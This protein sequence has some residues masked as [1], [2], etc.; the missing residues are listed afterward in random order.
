[1]TIDRARFRRPVQP[2]VTLRIPVQ[3]KRHR[4]AVWR[5]EGSA[6]IGDEL[7]AEAEYSAML[8]DIS[9]GAAAAAWSGKE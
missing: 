6:Y 8:T 3:V 7:C 4:G 5:F 2:D 1:M 9:L